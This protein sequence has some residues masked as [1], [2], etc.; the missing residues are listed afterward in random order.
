MTGAPRR[1]GRS[2]RS[3]PNSIGGQFTAYPVEMLESPAWRALSTTAKRCIERIAIELA[4]HGGRDN[5]ELPVTN[6]NFRDYGVPMARIKPALA[7]AVAL[8]FIDMTPGHASQNPDY[9]RAARFRILFLNCIGPLPDHTRWQRLKTHDEAKLMAK[10]ARSSAMRKRRTSVPSHASPDAS[11]SE[12]LASAS[13]GEAL[14]ASPKVKHCPPAQSEALSTV[15]A[16]SA[17]ATAPDRAK[18]SADRSRTA[19]AAEEAELRKVDEAIVWRGKAKHVQTD[20]GE[21]VE[22]G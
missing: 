7:E 4:H 5:G 18:R 15:S 6:R 21:D 16:A 22:N 19:A 17:V 8:G 9:G 14:S 2:R 13:P 1:S 11:Q 3:K 20:N 12:A 10:L